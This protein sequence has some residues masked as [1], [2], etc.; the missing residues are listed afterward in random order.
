LS[1]PIGRVYDRPV[2][3][4][5]VVL[6]LL[7]SGCRFGLRGL[8]IAS[9]DLAAP[10]DAGDGVDLLA[11]ALPDLADP[12][13]AVTLA[14]SV[15]EATCARAGAPPVV[16]GD[17]GEWSPGVFYTISHGQA[18]EST[19]AWS[20]VETTNDADLSAQVAARWD[21]QYLYVGARITDDV[22][23]VPATASLWNDDAIEIYVDGLDDRGDNYDSDDVQLVIA[24]NGQGQLWKWPQT[25]YPTALPAGVVVAT[26]DS[27][28]GAAWNVEVAIPW[29]LLGGS[30]AAP[31]RTL[32]I[33]VQL[34]DNDLGGATRDRTL[35]WANAAPA[36][37][38]CNGGFCQPYCDQKSFATLELGGR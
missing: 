26:K 15:V 19:G 14:A 1:S 28:P 38:V 17:L 33:D 21:D 34:D 36:G 16:D 3:R 10:V 13:P 31:G 24:A 7:M 4:G 8:P 5:W 20:G 18:S 32:G 30:A 2:R 35:L 22:R 25:G 27:T 9:A 11:L 37:C 29:S 23:Q 6:L 12:C